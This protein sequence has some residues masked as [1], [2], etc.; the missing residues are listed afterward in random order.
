MDKMNKRELLRKK[1]LELYAR[2]IECYQTQL[3]NVVDIDEIDDLVIL[4]QISSLKILRDSYPKLTKSINEDINV[5]L[6]QVNPVDIKNF[7][8]IN[9]LIRN[10]TENELVEMLFWMSVFEGASLTNKQKQLLIE[11]I[12]GFS[13][14]GKYKDY[15]FLINKLEKSKERVNKMNKRQFTDSEMQKL[16]PNY[17]AKPQEYYNEY[18]NYSRKLE[19]YERAVEQ[20][21]QTGDYY[22]KLSLQ[23]SIYPME[24]ECET[25]EE[26]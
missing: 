23:Y 22:R 15:R 26:I 17:Y 12:S 3:D 2:G 5:L 10:D 9:F 8:K 19:I 16:F 6:S 20:A 24:L 7:N 11:I 18:L 21:K 25:S 4:E 1:V 14:K 13:Y